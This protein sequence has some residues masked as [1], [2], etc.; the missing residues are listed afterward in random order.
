MLKL[1]HRVRI[2]QGPGA[3]QAHPEVFAGYG[4]RCLIVTGSGSAKKCGA[5]DDCITALKC[6]H[7]AYEVFDRIEPNPKTATCHAAGAAARDF[8][9]EFI[10]GIGGG[11]PMD[12]AK[13]VA[14]Y[15]KNPSFAHDGVY[16][17]QIPAQ[18]LPV[19]L[20]GTT[21]GTGSEVTGVSV[22]TH[23]DTGAKKSISGADC[24]AEAAFCDYS[25]T[26]ALPQA[27]TV[28]TALDALAHAVESA[29]TNRA[30]EKSR[31][32]S[33][34]AL[35]LLA[36]YIL[37]DPP[38]P[39]PDARMRQA[40]YEAS[41]YAGAAIDLTGTCFPHTLG[42]VLTEQLGVPHGLAC[43]VFMPALI[44]RARRFCP[45]ALAFVED[46]LGVP[47]E[48]V[49]AAIRP[50]LPPSLPLGGDAIADAVA[51]WQKGVANFTRSPGGLTPEE[52]RQALENV[53]K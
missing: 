21:A 48:T 36:P 26:A 31:A 25:Y 17:R 20:I 15:A 14:I 30:N 9:A 42:Y 49:L 2:F 6:A 22:L 39:V 53:S 27:T 13:A 32:F 41:V 11:S 43:V 29:L 37:S 47:M 52:A 3:V 24:Y 51:R 12:A 19:I 40:L 4:R 33:A 38:F 46:A 7:I 28:S 16:T 1:E 44:G 10:V 5:L 18:K 45:D 50:A 23:S 8:G 34:Q 35:G